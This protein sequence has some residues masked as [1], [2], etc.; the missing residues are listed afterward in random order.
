M[1]DLLE[2]A[3]TT[4][5]ALPP[6]LQDE[7]ARVMLLMANDEEPIQLSPEE[8]ADLDASDAE[9]ARGELATDDRMRAI[10][11]KHGA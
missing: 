6:A 9:V 7:I 3:V 11:A 4:T 8:L 5:R 1:T 10:W 2:K